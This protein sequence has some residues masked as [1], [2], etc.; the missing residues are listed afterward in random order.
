MHNV[1][2]TS[3]NRSATSLFAVTR[4]QVCMNDNFHQKILS[5][6]YQLVILAVV[7]KTRP[8]AIKV[9]SHLLVNVILG[10]D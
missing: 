2:R 9:E 3:L 6:S 4:V 10:L 1:V 5:F 7:L 8:A